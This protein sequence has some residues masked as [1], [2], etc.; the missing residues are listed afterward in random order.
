MNGLDRT[1]AR[2][3]VDAGYMPVADYL[4][5]FGEEPLAVAESASIV[6]QAHELVN[7]FEYVEGLRSW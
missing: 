4:D 3:L 6:P 1:T 5:M 2:A 7:C